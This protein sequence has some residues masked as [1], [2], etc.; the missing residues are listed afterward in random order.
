MKKTTFY[1]AL[2]LI[3][4]SSVHAKNEMD[5]LFNTLNKV[6]ENEMIYRA[7]KERQIADLKQM[8]LTPQINPEQIYNIQLKLYYEYKSYL[9]DSAIVYNQK[10]IQL[11]EKLGYTEWIYESKLDLV[12]IYSIT[13]KFVEASD[14]LRNV[15]VKQLSSGLQ[16]KYFDAYKQFYNSYSH[17]SDDYKKYCDY[18]C[19]TLLNLYAPETNGYKMLYAEKLAASGKIADAR[20]ILFQLLDS[21]VVE[22]S[23]LAILAC[24][25]GETYQIEGNYAM[26]KKYFTISAI[27]DIKNATKENISLR[28]L[29]LALYETG[30]VARAYQYIQKSMEDAIFSN[31]QLRSAETNRIFPI[32]EK[33][34]QE[35]IKQQKENLFTLLVCVIV[36]LLFLIVAVVYVYVQMKRLANARKK[37]S[38]LNDDLKQTNGQM[39]RMNVKLSE[40][41]VLKEKYIAHYMEQSFVYLNKM[42][43]YLRSLNRLASSG[44]TEELYRTLKSRQFLEDELEEFYINFDRSFLSLFPNFIHDFNALLLEDKQ[45]IP[46][47]KELLNTELRI[48]ALIRLGITD[49]EKIAQFLRYPV[50]TIYNYRARI[51]NKAAG[52]RNKLEKNVMQIEMR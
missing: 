44:K 47:Q 4:F 41:N 52:E 34:Y 42:E 39:L 37:L 15:P 13:D 16:I 18:Y 23:W 3:A 17:G 36:L 14:I 30:D 5:S 25:I 19:D 45:I 48:F 31:A 29:A 32:I 40:S 35:Q 28:A 38:E 6:I 33:A 11:S 22:N 7:K 1:I 26:Q 50:R 9:L 24:R 46:K 2:L 12:T 49:S 43:A 20:D 21:A 27:A 51:R 10:N 8:L